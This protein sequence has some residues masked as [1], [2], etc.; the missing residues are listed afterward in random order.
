MFFFFS[1][2][3]SSTPESEDHYGGSSFLEPFLH[4]LPH[5][6]D[7]QERPLEDDFLPHVLL[8]PDSFELLEKTERRLLKKKRRNKPKKQ[9]HRHFNDLWVR[10]E[11][12]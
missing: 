3:S 6:E 2:K 12:R 1:R 9:R 11:E 10:I 7:D 4:E 5:K 8:P